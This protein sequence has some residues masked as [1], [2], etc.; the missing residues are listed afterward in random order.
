M[1][2]SLEH[3]SALFSEHQNWKLPS[4]MWSCGQIVVMSPPDANLAALSLE[5]ETPWESESRK[6]TAE[7]FL[8]S[9]SFYQ[10][11][12]LFPRY[13]LL[14]V[15]YSMRMLEVSFCSTRSLVSEE[16]NSRDS[17]I[18]LRGTTSGN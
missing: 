10:T 13:Q 15:S 6:Q 17:E 11:T 14:P 12:V 5:S 7:S 9:N 8:T 4:A 18:G 16:G 3:V 2:L 1:S